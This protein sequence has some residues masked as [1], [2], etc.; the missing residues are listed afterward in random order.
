[1]SHDADDLYA[2]HAKI[3]QGVSSVI[4]A[5]ENFAPFVPQ[6]FEIP[7]VITDDD[8]CT[9]RYQRKVT[10]KESV[11]KTTTHKNQPTVDGQHCPLSDLKLTKSFF[12][13][14]NV[15]DNTFFLSHD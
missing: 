1:M 2:L 5:I 11:K 13:Q 10:S 4:N 8:D 14:A 7:M 6:A 15:I 12:H 9:S 3:N